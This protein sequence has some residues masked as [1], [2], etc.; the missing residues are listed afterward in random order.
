MAHRRHRSVLAVAGFVTAATVL[1]SGC[2]ESSGGGARSSAA[3]ARA[4]QAADAQKAAGDQKAAGAG[5]AQPGPGTP[6]PAAP[7]APTAPA[8]PRLIAYSAQLSVRAKDVGRA[9]GEARSLTAAG[10]GYVS[11]ESESGGDEGGAYGGGGNPPG[12]RLT[13]KVPS[14]SYQQTLDRF[15][16]LGAVVSRTSQAEDLTQQ[17]VDVNSRLKSQ[18]A[19]VDRVRALMNEAKSLSDVVSLEAELSRREA[20]LESLQ[21]QQQELSGRTSLSTITLEVYAENTPVAGPKK[22]QDGFWHSIGGALG[23]GWHV[24]G[25]ILRGLL[26]AVAAVAPFLLVLAPLGWMAWRLRRRPARAL[27]AEEQE[28]PEAREE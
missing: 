6:A 8:D 20:D 15:S 11:A 16:G 27:A 2:G 18:Q 14:A 3:A 7:T 22:H 28:V 21:R 25:A 26:I 5:A 19:S 4:P 24:F 10:G 17:V 1:V 12:A 9:V 13:V 23:G